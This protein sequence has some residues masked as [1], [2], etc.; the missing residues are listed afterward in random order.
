MQYASILSLLF[1]WIGCAEVRA[2]HPNEEDKTTNLSCKSAFPSLKEKE[3]I[4][5][6]PDEQPVS[7][8]NHEQI[9]PLDIPCLPSDYSQ[10]SE[11]WGISQSQVEYLFEHSP[12]LISIMGDGYHKRINGKVWQEVLG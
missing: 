7:I 9:P 5:V 2:T 8:F 10:H 6:S 12:D 1:L 11:Y 4:F 3:H